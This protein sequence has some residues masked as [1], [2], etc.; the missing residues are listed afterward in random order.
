M[1]QLYLTVVILL[2]VSISSTVHAAFTQDPALNWKTLHT[3]HFSIHYHDGE[4]ELAKELANI[5]ETVHSQ[6]SEYMQWTPEQ[7][8]QVILTDRMDF[9]NGWAYPIPHNTMTLIVSPPDDLGTLEDFDN[10]LELVFIHEYTHILHLDKVFGAPEVLR[11]VLGRFDSVLISTFPNAYQPAWILEGLAT[12][13]ETDYKKNVGRGQNTSFKTLM[14]LEVE[15]GIKSLRQVNQ[16]MVSWPAGTTRYL[17]GVY[18]MNFL[19]DRYGDDQLRN[20]LHQYSNNFYWF[21]NLNASRTLG[22]N[23]KQLWQEFSEYLEEQFRPTI[24][25]IKAQGV[26]AGKNISNAG[27]YT[28]Y[29]RSLPNGNV[30]YIRDDFASHTKLMVLEKGATKSRIVADV[31]SERFDIHPA[32]GLLMAKVDLIKSVNYFSDLYQVDFDGRETRLTKGKRYTFAAW[33]PDGKQIAAVQNDTGDKALHLLSSSGEFL[34]PLWQGSD[35]EVIAQ[36]DWSPNGNTIV[37]AVW[38]SGDGWNLEEFS[39]QSKTWRKITNTDY[40]EAQPQYTEDGKAILFSADYDGVFN[41]MRL[42]INTKKLTRLT[43]LVGG[44]FSVTE[45]PEGGG[46]YYTGI[47]ENGRDVYHLEKIKPQVITTNPTAS[48]QNSPVK[49][50]IKNPLADIPAD[51]SYNAVNAKITD[52]SALSKL[53]PTAWAPYF[54]AD[55]D[56]AEVGFSTFGADPLFR[57]FYSLFYGYDFDSGLSLGQLDYLYDRWNPTIKL[58]AKREPLRFYQSDDLKRVR[59]EE[60]LT[61]ELI[62]PFLKRNRQWALHL[63]LVHD[64]ESDKWFDRTFSPQASETDEILGFAT[65]YNSAHYYPKSI[66]LT[67]GQRFRIVAEDSDTLNSDYTGQVYTLDWRGYMEIAGRHVLATRLT[68][69]WGTDNPQPFRLGGQDEGYVLGSPGSTVV[70][71]TTEIF[72]KRDYALRGYDEG[73]S[74]LS[75]RR[76]AL[77]ELEYRFPIVMIERGFMAPPIGIHNIH[78]KVFYNVGDAWQDDFDSSDLF[79]GAGFEVNTEVVLGYM[80]LLD[81]RV[82][83]AHGFDRELGEDVVYISAGGTF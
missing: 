67:D 34:Q 55:D 69:G 66:S 50:N 83:Y 21:V 59:M 2:L 27:Y 22:K 63:G 62:Y 41:A 56:V 44:A 75:G 12:Y 47:S 43:N 6:L 39:L 54:Y 64:K 8:T 65:S 28:G 36:P 80:Y 79:H 9:S 52:Y 5:A 32:N 77:A 24:D 14:R 68:G 53:A 49:E 61:G 1:R 40:I 19:R 38:R 76:M 57:H 31:D 29:P 73:L 25:R 16:P 7:P 13:L 18:F 46:I 51:S 33:S 48:R 37:A 30:Y 11:K 26:T 82:G 70:L 78:G 71:P 81:L 10:W 3:P 17:Y 72:N 60:S 74:A 42:D 4:Q 58:S 23:F 35:K 15:N 45:A 20:W